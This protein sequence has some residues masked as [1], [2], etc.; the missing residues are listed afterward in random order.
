[1]LCGFVAAAGF[2]PLAD[3]GNLHTAANSLELQP[4]TYSCCW[5]NSV[6]L[7]AIS[8]LACRYQLIV[9]GVPFTWISHI[10]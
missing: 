2:P 7:S 3:S 6:K 10:F 5:F 9:A 8:W 1:M 4:D